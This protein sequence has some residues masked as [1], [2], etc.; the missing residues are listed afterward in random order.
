MSHEKYIETDEC[1]ALD[2]VWYEYM[3]VVCLG[4]I[5]SQPNKM[6]HGYIT[7]ILSVLLSV[8]SALYSS[9]MEIS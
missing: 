1:N 5:L 8:P 3:C 4:E 9:A 6:E 2:L 7:L